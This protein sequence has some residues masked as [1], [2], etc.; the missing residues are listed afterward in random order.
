MN[1]KRVKVTWKDACSHDEWV[2]IEDVDQKTPTINTTGWLIIEND[3][4]LVVA[5]SYDRDNEKVSQTITIP[6]GMVV[7]CIDII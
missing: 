4:C 2:N 5:L 6:R 7:S 3:D 1:V